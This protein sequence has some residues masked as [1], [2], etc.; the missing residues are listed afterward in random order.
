MHR[1]YCLAIVFCTLIGCDK[2]ESEKADSTKSTS[3]KSG[4]E[5]QKPTKVTKVTAKPIAQADFPVPAGMK[6]GTSFH[7]TR[8][9][10]MWRGPNMLSKYIAFYEKKLKAAGWTKN[11][12]ES[13][14]IGGVG[15][16]KFEKGGLEITLTMNPARDGKR[17]SIFAKG[18]GVSVP[19][20]DE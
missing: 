16:L 19:K 8:S 5:K 15:F 7:D 10:I 17:M 6:F 1:C 2:S 11:S 9:T 12:A 18:T 14:T 3:S 20:E 4:S 13:E